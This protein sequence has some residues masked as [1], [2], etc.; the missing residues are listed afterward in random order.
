VYLGRRG[1]EE[2]YCAIREKVPATLK[3]TR[4]FNQRGRAVTKKSLWK[5]VLT[6]F[7]P[8]AVITMVCA[9]PD[10]GPWPMFRCNARH[11]GRSDA[12]GPQSAALLWSYETGDQI[13]SSASIS[14][15]GRIYIGSDDKNLYAFNPDGT[16]AWTFPGG[17]Y[18]TCAPAIDSNERIYLGVSYYSGKNFYA[19]ESTGQI[20]WS[21]D[22]EVSTDKSSP[23]I[24]SEGNCYIGTVTG[25][26]CSFDS[27]GGLNWSFPT[28]DYF[29]DSSPALDGEGHLYCGS[30]NKLFFKLSASNGGLG[31]SYEAGGAL[32]SSPAIDSEGNVYVGS[33]DNNVYALS[34]AGTLRWSY[35]TSG[36]VITSA[37]I[38]PD[39]RVYVGS[40]GGEFLAFEAVSGDVAWSYDMGDQI[41]SSS[42]LSSNGNVYV[43]SDDNTLYAFRND[44]TVLWLYETE[45]NIGSS[46]SLDADGNL[47]VGSSDSRV[48]VFKGEPSPTP[49]GTTGIQETPAVTPTPAAT[50]T[51]TATLAAL[52]PFGFAVPSQTVT[53]G[54]TLTV[55]VV[56]NETVSY[57]APFKPWIVAL[58]P[59]G[60]YAFV[61]GGGRFHRQRGMKP[62]YGKNLMRLPGIQLPPVLE[63]TVQS[64]L[65][66]GLYT[67]IA[68]LCPVPPGRSIEEAKARAFLWAES[69]VEIF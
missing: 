22:L 30:S 3:V 58:S 64:S 68:A 52:P 65:P 34:P 63:L 36:F 43:G 62:A 6:S 57:G 50:P 44:G 40:I 54:E 53:T 42:A 56:I 31:W 24:D 8:L 15:S 2:I 28:G 60:N 33:H 21:Y 66:R 45:G 27:I 49:T 11:T 26:M 5:P 12:Y 39:D 61:Y 19:L 48:Y 1:T 35:Q 4:L 16:L 10:S 23:V 14:D 7:I 32:A 13:R 25:N 55:R 18:I 37:G 9:Q 38:G 67:F 17:D 29:V 47:Y 46:P 20:T 69:V 51:P 59:A 41:R